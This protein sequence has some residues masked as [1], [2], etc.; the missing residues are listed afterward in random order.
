MKAAE[1]IY[2][3]NKA[4]NDENVLAAVNWQDLGYIYKRKIATEMHKLTFD[5]KSRI[6]H[7][8]CVG[9]ESLRKERFGIKRMRTELR[10][11]IIGIH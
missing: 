8:Y 1:A 2:R 11:P 4:V 10:G 3:S 9:R 5:T 6:A 7:Q